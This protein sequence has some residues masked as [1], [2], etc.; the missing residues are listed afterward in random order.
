MSLINVFQEDFIYFLI[1]LEQL[2]GELEGT[3]LNLIF[4]KIIKYGSWLQFL[5]RLE[6]AINVFVA[7][8]TFMNF[9]LLVAFETSF[10]DATF[11]S[12][13]RTLSSIC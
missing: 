7:A 1:I 5:I 6:K 13:F 10:P 12:F 8:L 2:L 3:L 11:H 4:I 9:F